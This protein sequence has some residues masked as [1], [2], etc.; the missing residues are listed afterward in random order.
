M[1]TDSGAATRIADGYAVDGQALELGT[2]VIDGA[3]DPTAQIR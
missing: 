3:A 2:V 1:S